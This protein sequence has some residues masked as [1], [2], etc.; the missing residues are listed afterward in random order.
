[1]TFQKPRESDFNIRSIQEGGGEG[2]GVTSANREKATKHRDRAIYSFIE[3]GNQ[4]KDSKGQ[5]ESS[6]RARG[7]GRG[8]R[9]VRGRGG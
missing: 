4:D 2:E 8:K 5:K 3:K 6:P 9:M 7:G 1:V